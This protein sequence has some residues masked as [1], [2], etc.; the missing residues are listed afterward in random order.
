MVLYKG[1]LRP[2][3]PTL[4]RI[5]SQCLTGTSLARRN[6]TCGKQL[7][8][9]MQMIRKKVAERLSTSNRKGAALAFS[10]GSRAYALQDNGADTVEANELLGLAVDSRDYRQ[11]AE[12]LY[13]MGLCQVRVISQQSAQAQCP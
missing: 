6:A 3:I 4:V 7:T 5:H 9:T 11:C 1:E 2:E 10:T 12:I 13:D 8:H